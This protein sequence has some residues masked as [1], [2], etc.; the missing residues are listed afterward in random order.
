MDSKQYLEKIVAAIGKLE[1]AVIKECSLNW[2]N[3]KNNLFSGWVKKNS[4]WGLNKN[5]IMN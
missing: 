5:E 1:V 4:L 2:C 3:V